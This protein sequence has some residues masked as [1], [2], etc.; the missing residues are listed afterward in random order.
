[1]SKESEKLADAFRLFDE[2]NSAD[3][4]KE[5]WDGK[6][7]PK[8][9]LYAQRMTETLNRFEP[10]ASIA[11]QLTARC[12]H[13]QRWEIPRNSFEMNRSGY[14]QW[15]Q[16][17]KKYHAEVARKILSEVGFNSSVIDKVEFLLLKKQLKK[18]EETQTL[19]DVICLVFLEYYYEAFF[20]KHD[21]QKVI[22][23]LQKTWRKM[24]AKGH[25]AA[26]KISFSEPGLQLVKTAVLN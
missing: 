7:I 22:D 9:L 3:P 6:V 14:L 24:S 13:I 2:A 21:D 15:R 5:L 20:Q 12:Q 25:E 4:N 17:L 11:L 19:E 16:A 1:M 8:E 23:I 18:N 26:L 10:S